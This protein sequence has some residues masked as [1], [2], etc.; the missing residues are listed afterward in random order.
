MKS[1]HMPRLGAE[2]DKESYI[3]LAPNHPNILEAIEAEVSAGHTAQQVRLFVIRQTGRPEIALRCE[4]A[5]R[6]ISGID[7]AGER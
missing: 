2:L 4:Q 3:W 5:A 7:N 1:I 6:Y